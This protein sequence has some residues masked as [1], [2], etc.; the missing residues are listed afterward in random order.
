[1]SL[2]A[3]DLTAIRR[4]VR[5]ELE[6]ALNRR[7]RG[8]SVAADDERR[9]DVDDEE[10]AALAAKTLAW[11]AEGRRAA[12]ARAALPIP[13]TPFV[14]CYDA[15]RLLDVSEQTVRKYMTRGLLTR[16][17]VNGRVEVSRVEID[18]ILS[19]RRSRARRGRRKPGV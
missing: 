12:D 14:D 18:A 13:D 9:V 1:M 7:R 2:T 19:T 4:V 5:E 10:I 15:S 3:S 17:I 16:R 6:H 8:E 11:F